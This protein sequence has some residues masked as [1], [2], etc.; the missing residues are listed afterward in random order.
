M[1]SRQIATLVP[2]IEERSHKAFEVQAALHGRKVKPRPERTL[3][4][5]DE[6]TDIA[7]DKAAEDAYDRL[8]SRFISKQIKGQK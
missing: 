2:V 7:N 6:K 8:K 1:T 3:L 4:N 5:V